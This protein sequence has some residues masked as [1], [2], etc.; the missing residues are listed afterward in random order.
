M[1]KEYWV[2]CK[3]H[4]EWQDGCTLCTMHKHVYDNYSAYQ[5]MGEL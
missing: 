1:G 2:G 5:K 4:E 3:D